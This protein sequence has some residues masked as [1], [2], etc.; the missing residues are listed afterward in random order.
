MSLRW[1][2]LSD[3]SCTI[4]WPPSSVA[5]NYP[6]IL[7]GVVHGNI[8]ATV[9]VVFA[10]IFGS[11][12]QSVMAALSALTLLKKPPSMLWDEFAAEV[13]RLRQALSEV[14]DE[15]LKVGARVIPLFV[16]QA[17]DADPR[18]SVELAFLRRLGPD[19]TVDRI[20]S[21]VQIKML[22]LGAPVAG[23]VA[24]VTQRAKVCYNYRDKGA[25]KFGDNCRFEHAGAGGGKSKRQP[26]GV[27]Y[28]CGSSKHGIQSCPVFK[29]RKMAES[30]QANVAMVPSGSLPSYPTTAADPGGAPAGGARAVEGQVAMLMPAD[31]MRVY[32]VDAEFERMV[33]GT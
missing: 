19:V 20:M 30:D 24:A 6:S 10:L 9:R 32:G 12:E 25:C 14:Q 28:E 15:R 26:K 11:S 1:T 4:A 23:N 16:L 18:L 27:C 21:D 7:S 33:K 22:Q 13:T 8:A 29:S 2:G 31:A 17:L 3:C 5:V